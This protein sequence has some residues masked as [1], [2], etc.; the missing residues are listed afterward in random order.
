MV[1]WFYI[2][3]SIAVISIDT[4]FGVNLPVRT[5]E[6]FHIHNKDTYLID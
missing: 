4:I 1:R 2:V 6:T 5:I 3:Q